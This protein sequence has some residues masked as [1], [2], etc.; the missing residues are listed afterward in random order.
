MAEKTFNLKLTPTELYYIHWGITAL[1]DNFE[2]PEPHHLKEVEKLDKRLEKKDYTEICWGKK[3]NLKLKEE[4]EKLKDKI[5]D[6][7]EQLNEEIRR[8]INE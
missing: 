1:Y 8:K 6:L 3:Q 2:E 7:Q 4:N 5:D